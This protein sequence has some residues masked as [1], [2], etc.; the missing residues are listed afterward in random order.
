MESIFIDEEGK[1]N[2]EII[3][4]LQKAIGYSLT[5]ETT[6]QVMFFLFGN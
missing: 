6:E 2:Y 5:G 1:P 3:E 4:F